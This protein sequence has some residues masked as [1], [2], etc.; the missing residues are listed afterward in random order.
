[1]EKQK[2]ELS[3]ACRMQIQAVKDTQDVLSGKWKTVIIAALYNNG[4]LRFM[5]LQ[6]HIEGIAPKTLAKE[7]KDLEMNHLVKRTVATTM[8]I[9]VE[10][11]LTSNG[12]S[13]NRVVEAMADWGIHYRKSILAQ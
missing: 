3:P 2:I 7:L 12:M 9:R 5:E 13:L 1:M 6:R 11:A 4:T 10:Y 8:P